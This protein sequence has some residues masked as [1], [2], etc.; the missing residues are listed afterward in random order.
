MG[1]V[2][3]IGTTFI[4]LHGSSVDPGHVRRNLEWDSAA[5]VGLG[6]GGGSGRVAHHAQRHA[7][8]SLST[9]EKLAIGNYSNYLGGFGPSSDGNKSSSAQPFRSSHQR[10]GRL[11]PP[12]P[13]E[14]GLHTNAFL[15]LLLFVK[16]IMGL[17]FF[18]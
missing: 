10:G 3:I 6:E 14:A 16:Q 4:F 12:A 7:A 2:F 18:R 15:F 8:A 9:L 5:D 11:L 1:S 13:S 17:P